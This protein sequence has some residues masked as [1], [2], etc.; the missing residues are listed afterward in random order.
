[1]MI[2]N[3]DHGIMG[4]GSS[5]GFTYIYIT[6]YNSIWNR[7]DFFLIFIPNEME[8]LQDLMI[9]SWIFSKSSETKGVSFLIEN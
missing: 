4:Y 6:D 7:T 1:M 9:C 5:G 8:I 3:D 2:I